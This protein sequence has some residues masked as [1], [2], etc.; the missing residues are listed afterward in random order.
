MEK[1]KKWHNVTIL[2]ALLQNF[3]LI[4]D[5]DKDKRVIGYVIPN[6][7]NET[8]KFFFLFGH[9]FITYD[10]TTYKRACY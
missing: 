3:L 6:P 8:N 2:E 4:T 5:E 7:K 10:I 9:C 1:M